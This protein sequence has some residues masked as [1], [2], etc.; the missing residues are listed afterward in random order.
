MQNING[1]TIFDSYNDFRNY[2]IQTMI[3]ENPSLS[4]EYIAA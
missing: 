1:K 4:P 3:N 2:Y